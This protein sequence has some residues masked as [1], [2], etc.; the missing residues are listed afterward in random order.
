MP[1][2]VLITGAAKRIGAGCVRTLHAEGFNVVLHYHSSESM[3]REL[4]E[5]LN[6]VRSNSVFLVRADLLH[7]D[8]VL[9]L[10]E[11]AEKVWGGLNALVNNASL[12]A[13][14]AVG[15]VSEAHWDGLMATNLKAPFFLSQALAPALSKSTGCIVNIAD[16]HAERGLPGYCSYSVAKAGLVAMTKALAKELAPDI[17][18]NAVSPGAILWP[19]NAEDQAR[20]AEIL[21]KIPLQ[22]C[23]AVDD[24]ARAVRFLICEAGYMTGQVLSVD[25]GRLLFS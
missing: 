20:V 13:A 12:F 14:D 21:Q 6:A 22:R 18:V 2:V 17:R 25:G 10:A 8:E 7:L 11:E 4:M 1:K 15:Q 3:A 9:R 19:E 24:I 23:G 5:Q 16:I